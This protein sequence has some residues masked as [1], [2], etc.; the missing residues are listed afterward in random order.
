[1]HSGRRGC[2]SRKVTTSRLRYRPA[3]SRATTREHATL[4]EGIDFSPL[5][6]TRTLGARRYFPWQFGVDY[7]IVGRGSGQP[8]FDVVNLGLL[9]NAV[10]EPAARDS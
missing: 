1:M 10:G 5:Q 6:H 7:D 3:T 9:Q 4:D 8:A 2:N